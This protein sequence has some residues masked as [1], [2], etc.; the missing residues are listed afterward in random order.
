MV[1][2]YNKKHDKAMISVPSK[3]ILLKLILDRFP[4]HINS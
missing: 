4:Y 1:R 2:A 3:L